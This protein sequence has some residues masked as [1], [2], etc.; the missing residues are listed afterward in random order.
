MFLQILTFN[1]KRARYFVHRKEIKER[2]ELTHAFEFN[3]TE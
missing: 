3:L 1:M 2:I